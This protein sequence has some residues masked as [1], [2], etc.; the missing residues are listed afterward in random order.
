MTTSDRPHI[1]AFMD[2][3]TN[4]VRLLI[5]RVEPNHAYRILTDQKEMVR[6]GEDEFIEQRLQPKA[7]QRAALICAKFA[8]LA[9]SHG[10]HDIA[11]VATA[12]VREADN[13]K[14]FLRRLR[15]EAGLE[16]HVVS[17][18][19]EARLIYLGVSS[20]VHLGERTALFIDIGG[21]STEIIVGSQTQ[22]Y[23]LA[24]LK[25]GAIR[26][27]SLFLSDPAAPVTPEQYALIHRNVR[28]AAVRAIQQ[29]R[30]YRLDLAIGSSG[31]IDNLAE[32]AARMFNRRKRDRDGVLTHDQLKQ[33][34][35]VLCDLPLDKRR[36]LPGIN[37]ERA[38]IIIGGA[39][40]L[41]T[42]MQEFQVSEIAISERGL[43]DGLLM[44]YLS[45]RQP[46]YWQ[47]S[48]RQRSVLQLGRTCSFD[49][50][51]AQNVAALALELFDSAR[52]AGLHPLGAA[53][54]EWLHYAALL[55]DVGAFLAYNNHHAHTYYI[56]GNAELLGFDQTEIAIIAATALFHRKAFASPK[57]A[58]FAALD[59]PSR[60]IVRVLAVLLRMAENLNRGH[61]NV[62]RHADLRAVSNKKVKLT[63]H[64]AGDCQLEVWGFQSNQAAFEKELARAITIEIVSDSPE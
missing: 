46:D 63:V 29:V 23:F 51:H 1:A 13:K 10:A 58:E 6:L 32:I 4:S 61:T 16:V 55:H 34:V 50:A 39:A 40:V 35:K 24:S 56:I 12:A 47:M 15:Q 42:L 43:R 57:R 17:G 52:E 44:D 41:D 28:V 38:D 9:R 19:E 64:V 2:I 22:H 3:G 27:S 31:T 48:A 21:G 53:E 8:H 25:L 54:R 14:A 33:V 7:M 45:R 59:R 5:V 60:K 20:G 26:V 37:P 18:M 11:A 30:R 62:V 36:Q 49:E